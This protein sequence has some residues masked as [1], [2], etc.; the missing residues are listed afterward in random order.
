ML[1]LRESS[2][3]PDPVIVGAQVGET[4]VLTR[5]GLTTAQ[6]AGDGLLAQE[7]AFGV[8]LLAFDVAEP[9]LMFGPE[10]VLDADALEWSKKPGWGLAITS[11]RGFLRSFPAG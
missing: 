11:D 3:Y 1:G 6:A 4:S 9:P 2:A 5:A 7:G 8:L 10:G